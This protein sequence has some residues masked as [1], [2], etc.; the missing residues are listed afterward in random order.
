[1]EL[2]FKTELG[3]EQIKYLQ[4]A[5]AGHV[6]SVAFFHVFKRDYILQKKY[7]QQNSEMF[8]SVSRFFVIPTPRP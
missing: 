1:M 3:I 7:S 6:D 2:E 8:H 4:Q 5:L